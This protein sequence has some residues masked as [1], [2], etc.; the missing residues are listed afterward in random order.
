[1]LPDLHINAN[2]AFSH[3]PSTDQVDSWAQVLLKKSLCDSVVGSYTED[4][5]VTQPFGN[6][7]NA[8]ISRYVRFAAKDGRTF[9]GYWQPALKQPA[10]L[11]INLPGYGGC[12]SLHPQINDDGYHILHISPLGYITPRNIRE[13]LLLEDGNWPVLHNTAIGL[14]GGYEDWLLDC[15][16]AIRWAKEQPGVLADRVS[17]WHQPGRRRGLASGVHFAGS[18]SLCLRRSALPDGFSPDRTSGRG[19]RHPSESIWDNF[20]GRLLEPPGIY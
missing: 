3:Y 17:L 9:Y 13:D 5:P 6:G 12:I 14:P 8:L 18:A 19:L 15:L 7:P 16:L 11:L 4:A 10:P 20:G 2:L 1:M